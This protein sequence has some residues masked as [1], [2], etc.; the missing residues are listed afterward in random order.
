MINKKTH[1]ISLLGIFCG[2]IRL[3]FGDGLLT[4]LAICCGFY[5]DTITDGGHSSS[6]LNVL[7]FSLGLVTD[8]CGRLVKCIDI[9][10]CLGGY[11]TFPTLFL[12]TRCK[13]EK[14]D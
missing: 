7:N 10:W 1:K 6:F 9:S 14:G 8:S 13:G 11:S 4:G 3:W 5:S 12:F 2:F